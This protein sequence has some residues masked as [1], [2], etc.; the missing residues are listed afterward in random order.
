MPCKAAMQVIPGS[1]GTDGFRGLGNRTDPGS[2]G[3]AGPRLPHDQVAGPTPLIPGGR[4]S[5]WRRARW[6]RDHDD[7]RRA[8]QRWAAFGRLPGLPGVGVIGVTAL[9]LLINGFGE[10]TG[11]RGFA[12]PRFRRRHA[13]LQASILVAMPWILWHAPTFFLDSGYRGSFNPLTLPGFV[14]AMFA[15]AIVLTFI[16]EGAGASILLAAIWHTA[17]NMGSATEAGEGLVAA[18][19]SAFVIGWG[20]LVAR[21]WR[22]R[23]DDAQARLCGTVGCF[24]PGVMPAF[25][26]GRPASGRFA[27]SR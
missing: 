15:G 13:R 10:E 20:F 23:E 21:T 6:R 16:Y 7:R 4:T 14:V 2:G 24:G 9:T 19:V 25:V 22:R 5:S 27:S 12:L 11:W 1:A 8:V 3:L 26:P 17:P 18:V